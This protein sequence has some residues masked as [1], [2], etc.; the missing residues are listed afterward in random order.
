MWPKLDSEEVALNLASTSAIKEEILTLGDIS[1]HILK[2]LNDYYP[3]KL[4]ERYGISKINNDDIMETFDIIGRKRGALLRGN[5]V[6]YDKVYSLIL[7]DIKDEN[8]K[9]ITFDRF[10]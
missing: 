5:I 10:N 2:K 1:F 7:R 8:I 9:G 6:D 4:N 3:E